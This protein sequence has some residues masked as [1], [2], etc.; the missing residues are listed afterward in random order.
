MVVCRFGAGDG[1]GRRPA[2]EVHCWRERERAS[3]MF[4][5]MR[6]MFGRMKWK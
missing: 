3:E 6:E 1:G 5:R 2:M 4:G